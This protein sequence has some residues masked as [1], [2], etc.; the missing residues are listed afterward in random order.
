MLYEKIK[1]NVPY[2]KIGVSAEGCE[3]VLTAIVPDRI[4]NSAERPPRRA[5]I[6]CPG[7]GYDYCSNRESE[8][9]AMRF[10]SHN[11]TAFVLN[12][13]CYKK[14]FPTNLAELAAAFK[15][16]RDNSDKFGI[17]REKIFVCGFSA[18]GHLAAS[19]GVHWNK[20]FLYEPLNVS[21]EEIKPCGQILSYPVITAGEKRHDG[22]ILNL[23]GDDS[24]I[25]LKELVSLEKQVSGDTVPTFI[26][27]TCDD[28]LVP[29]ENTLLFTTALA[30]N[31]VPF[32]SH[33][34]SSG[35]HGLALSDETT[36]NCDAHINKECAEWISLA[37]EWMQRQ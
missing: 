32:T 14:P 9:V 10:V 34:F 18:G 7:G 23:I 16:V 29:V 25:K 35:A 6:I 11:I 30:A 26:W 24:N 31:K 21:P 12:Y 13:S 19:L 22:S 33:I 1:L 5:V 27:C 17:D 8:P 20:P 37:M 36:A 15:F 28:S 3:A 4:E 2:E